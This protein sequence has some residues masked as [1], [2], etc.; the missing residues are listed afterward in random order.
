MKLSRF[1]LLL[2]VLVALCAGA[3]A[4]IWLIGPINASLSLRPIH[5]E[6]PVRPLRL[7]AALLAVRL[8]APWVALAFLRLAPVPGR[9][10][11]SPRVWIPLLI[12]LASVWPLA[13]LRER[14]R[15]I[16]AVAAAR[17][18][19]WAQIG[20]ATRP[21]LDDLELL[22]GAELPD[23]AA[24][25]P[26]PAILE[27][28]C[29]L[30]DSSRRF[31][32]VPR[33]G[34]EGRVRLVHADAS[35][36]SGGIELGACGLRP[37]EWSTLRAPLPPRAD[38]ALMLRVAI[39]GDASRRA[40]PFACWSKP[41]I[42][43]PHDP[44]RL[45]LL[46]I[47][48]DTLRA[49]HLGVY[50][51]ARPTS[52]QIDQLAA[53]GAMFTQAFSQA[54]WTTPSHMSLFTSHFPTVHGVDAPTSNRQRK[55]AAGHP[56]LATVLQ[57]AGYATAAFTGSGS[58]SALYGFWRGFSVY[59]ETDKDDPA[60][61]GE[62]IS[63]VFEKASR[64][65]VDHREVPFFMFF[66]SYEAHAPYVHET[67]LGEAG[68]GDEDARLAA[69]YDGDILY[70]D[71][72]VGQ[73]I[74]L[75][76]GLGLRQRT[77]VVLL[78]D[79]GE[80]LTRRYPGERFGHG[81]TVYEELL[82]VPLLIA[83]EGR[84]PAG[85]RF[86]Q[87]VMLVDVMPTLLELMGVPGPK[88]MQGVSLAPALAGRP[89]PSRITFAEATNYGPERKSLRDGRFKYIRRF[90]RVDRPAREIPS[91]VPEEELFD[92]IADPGERR[93]LASS[94]SSDLLRLRGALDALVMLNHSRRASSPEAELDSET[95]R[96]L[97]ALG[98]IQ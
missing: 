49:D 98:Y 22:E 86:D 57:D 84:I 26:A 41:R 74:S 65:L 23:G 45:N 13:R 58:I 30:A 24:G 33:A 95:I 10:V 81:H 43:P 9:G 34:L 32:E 56:V 64:W 50:G 6:S 75:L 69:L 68:Q 96:R 52:P 36:G 77:V 12:L 97:K 71:G 25:G 90:D 15:A 92:L 82:R 72:F 40:A 78:S 7:A 17:A 31:L 47:S 11:R 67:F 1:T 37:G 91:E 48:L 3:A 73:L 83:A 20:L 60:R 70:A 76:D 5:W 87:P 66:H 54:P 2:N 85:V 18:E 61:R 51:H 28:D 88:G 38:R 46:L 55:L 53:R 93:S 89:Q 35:S 62:D 42:L 19:G 27:I 80:E 44:S 39:E 4:W 94:G 16:E 79:H 21:V 29:G 8:A 14:G 63:A 59:D